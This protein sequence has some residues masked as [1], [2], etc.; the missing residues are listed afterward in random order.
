MSKEGKLPIPSEE[1]LLEMDALTKEW[2]GKMGM[3]PYEVSNYAKEGFFSVH[4]YGYWSNV[5]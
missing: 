2:T 5:P 4:N 3:S 1:E